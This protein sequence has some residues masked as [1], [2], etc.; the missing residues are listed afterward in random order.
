MLRSATS[1]LHTDRPARLGTAAHVSAA[2][3]PVCRAAVAISDTVRGL[4]QHPLV[5][6][7]VEEVPEYRELLVDFGES[8]AVALYRQ[9]GEQVT[10]LA[11]PHQ[12]EAGY[13]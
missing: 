2:K 8:G 1:S 12:R 9:S 3:E 5:G 6:R 4:G 7:P 13:R 10:V 11:L